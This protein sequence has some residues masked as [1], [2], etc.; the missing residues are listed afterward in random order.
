[1]SDRQRLEGYFA[2][3]L[4][5]VRGEDVLQHHLTI[6]TTASPARVLR[7]RRGDINAQ[8][9]LPSPT[10]RLRLIALGK[11]ALSMTVGF[12]AVLQR[13]RLLALLDAAIVI[14]KEKQNTDFLNKEN[15][16]NKEVETA[17]TQLGSRWQLMRGGHPI[18]DERSLQAG[19]A[20]LDF[21]ADS[22]SH[23]RYLVL[24]SGGASA[25]AVQPIAGVT[26]SDKSAWVQSLMLTGAPI[27]ELNLLRRYLSRL[28]GGGLARA[29]APA[30]HL[31]LAISDVPGDDPRVIGSAPTRELPASRA[32]VTAMLDR[33]GLGELS[34]RLP[35]ATSS[36]QSLSPPTASVDACEST[37]AVIA[38]LDD[39]IEV[40]VAAGRRENHRVINLGRSFYGELAT[41][42]Q[43]FCRVIREQAAGAGDGVSTC[44]IIAAGEPI[45]RIEE[46]TRQ[47]EPGPDPEHDRLGGRAQHFA[48][49]CARELSNLS[50]VTVLAAGTDGSDGPTAAAGACVSGDTWTAIKASGMDPQ[51]ALDSYRSHPVLARVGALLQT[52]PTG[53]NVADLFI[54]LVHR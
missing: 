29:M 17:I 50:G 36:A 30:S 47:D 52:G 15:V 51:A 49:L 1:M 28:K 27:D 39:A 32:A 35:R 2:E 33:R 13:A 46:M 14:V 45:I 4:A 48:L 41:H 5:A 7:F 38:T 6:E 40:L 54:A 31:T 9:V 44:L 34:L 20:L 23:D 11:A 37:Y 12:L 19:R 21:V 26:L 16:L 10:G 3:A 8:M 53:T 18:A 25:L 42:A 22:D 24:L 43:E